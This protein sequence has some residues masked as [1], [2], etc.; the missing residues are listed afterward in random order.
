M[1]ARQKPPVVRWGVLGVA[2]IATAKVI[3]A[4]QRACHCEV[5]AIASR[6]GARAEAS[7]A[8]LGIPRA[9]GSYEA[10]L[11][12][13][14]VDAVYIP[15][16]NH[17]HVSWT[18]R[19]AEAGKHVLCEKPIALNAGE[20]RTLLEV[21]NR[22]GMRI[23]EA[24]M[25]RRHP[26]WLRARTLVDAGGLGD[27]RAMS[28]F[29]SYNNDDAS[30]VRNVAAFGGGAL[31]DI[32]CYLVNTA[33]FIF[34]AEPARVSGVSDIDPRFGVDRLTSM[35]LDFDGRH[36]IGTCGTQVQYYQ[37]IQ[38]VGTEG[39]LELE[40]PFNAPA[41]RPCRL[42]LDRTGDVHGSGIETIVLDTCNQYTLQAE[43]L[44]RA[45]LDC[46]PQ[47]APLED[48]VANMECIDALARSSRTG[49]WEP[50]KP[51]R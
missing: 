46:S 5:V 25:I 14:G 12:D 50:V 36:A 19:A 8:A 27:L 15:L 34:D 29:F 18:T 40:I 1:L 22:T 45:I 47:S 44:S 51:A 11:A 39:R 21:R 24:F 41:D 49:Q 32:G 31:L 48:A 28:G 17:L 10:L 4:M 38:I 20:A 37:R 26:Q 16:P 23:Q 6:D 43:E 2:R 3:P 7:A 35:I 33:R 9:H 42:T 13:P 30:N